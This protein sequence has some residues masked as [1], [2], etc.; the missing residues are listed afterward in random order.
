MKNQKGF[1]QVLLIGG[2]IVVLA[3]LGYVFYSQKLGAK[4]SGLPNLNSGYSSQN[5]QPSEVQT[6]PVQNVNDLNKVSASLDAEDTNQ[7]DSKLNQF[8]SAS[9][10]F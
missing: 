8:D 6:A 1:I 10:G 9:S 5:V 4:I 7:I 2:V 3:L